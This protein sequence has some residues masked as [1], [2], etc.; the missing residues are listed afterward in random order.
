MCSEVSENVFIPVCGVFFYRR[1][2]R[3]MKRFVSGVDNYDVGP[4]GREWTDHLTN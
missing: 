2:V 1:K 4:S 3:Q